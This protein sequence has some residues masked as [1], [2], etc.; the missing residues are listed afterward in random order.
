MGLCKI[1]KGG[2][3]NKHPSFVANEGVGSL[4]GNSLNMHHRTKLGF[5]CASERIRQQ[6]KKI[7]N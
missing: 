6:V 7:T 2:M 3:L 5:T 4:Y 1:P